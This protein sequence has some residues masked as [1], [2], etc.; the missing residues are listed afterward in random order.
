MQVRFAWR[1]G[2]DR[3]WG[4]TY[5][6]THRSRLISHSIQ[7]PLRSQVTRLSLTPRS[8]LTNCDAKLTKS[9]TKIL[10]S[11]PESALVTL[12]GLQR[13]PYLIG[14]S[15]QLLKCFALFR[16]FRLG[17]PSANTQVP[18]TLEQKFSGDISRQE[19]KDICVS[20]KVSH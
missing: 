8:T 19:T 7:W 20:K 4:Q 6:S 1:T 10:R 5:L 15:L 18:A 3:R 11:V 12:L 14:F 13:L 2:A 9:V 16:S 17:M